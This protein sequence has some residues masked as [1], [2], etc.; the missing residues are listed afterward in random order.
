[1]WIIF[2]LKGTFLGAKLNISVSRASIA[3]IFIRLKCTASELENIFSSVSLALYPCVLLRRSIRIRIRC[4][5]MQLIPVYL[6]YSLSFHLNQYENAFL[7]T[8]ST[9]KSF[10]FKWSRSGDQNNQMV[11]FLQWTKQ[12]K[13]EKESEKREK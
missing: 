4:C 13:R 10:H 7:V 9:T 8:G 11:R 5:E 3:F 6:V 1:M 12:Y 2:H